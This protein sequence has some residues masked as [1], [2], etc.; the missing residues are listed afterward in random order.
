MKYFFIETEMCPLLQ[1]HVSLL[2]F[3][4]LALA[5][6]L[7]H[8]LSR[9]CTLCRKVPA[10]GSWLLEA[11]SLPLVSNTFTSGSNFSSS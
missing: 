8:L 7:S 9:L 11:S 10:A 2:T 3:L 4:S 5:V 6:M 1:V